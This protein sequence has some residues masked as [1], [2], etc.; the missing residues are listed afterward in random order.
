MYNDIGMVLGLDFGFTDAFPEPSTELFLILPT[1]DAMSV[2]LQLRDAIE[3][4]IVSSNSLKITVPISIDPHP[5][6]FAYIVH[7]QAIEG[8]IGDA[9]HD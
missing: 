5:H 1:Q 7:K 3:D 8:V 2:F 4:V 6:I 9:I